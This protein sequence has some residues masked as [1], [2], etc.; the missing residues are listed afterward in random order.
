ML[1]AR[2]MRLAVLVGSLSLGTC[3]LSSPPR[4]HA[5]AR[6]CTSETCSYKHSSSLLLEQDAYISLVVNVT[7][8]AGM[9]IVSQPRKSITM[10]LAMAAMLSCVPGD[11]VETG[12]FNGGSSATIMRALMDMDDCNRTFYAFDSFE[13]LPEPTEQDKA[14]GAAA[15]SRG[16]FSVTQ[17]QFTDN[18]KRVHAWDSRIRVVKGWFNESIPAVSADIKSI[19]FL[20]LDGDL[21]SSTKDVLN[22]LYH[23]LNQGAT[24]YIDDYGSFNGCRKAVDE[25]R[26]EKN[27]QAPMH[28]VHEADGRV[29]AVW[30][31]HLT[32]WA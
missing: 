4:L 13:G 27:I 28:E 8:E 29:E 20:R 1:Q 26:A 10:Q 5:N 30:W 12:V 11:V 19:S 17:E 21:Y 32:N 7:N 3:A 23:K 6:A 24:I 15:G 2:F 31:Y 18:M 9:F 22:L 25:F 14:G 16:E